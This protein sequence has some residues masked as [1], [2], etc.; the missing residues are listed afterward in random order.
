[1]KNKD[2]IGQIAIHP[3]NENA[4]PAAVHVLGKN[5][6]NMLALQ[7]LNSGSLLMADPEKNTLMDYDFEEYEIMR[8]K[9]SIDHHERSKQRWI[10]EL[11]ELVNS[12]TTL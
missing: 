5:G 10:K 1:M 9:W 11:E 3:G 2:R 8:A 12:K 4:K 7:E 6:F